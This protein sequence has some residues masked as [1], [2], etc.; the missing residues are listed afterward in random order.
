MK[1]LL[2]TC[3]FLL[4]SNIFSQIRENEYVL[5]FITTRE[6]LS[7]NYV[8]S[9]VSDQ[10]NFK[11][12]GTENGITKYNGFDFDYLKPSKHYDKLLNENIETFLFDKDNNLWIGTKSGGL[13]YL[14]LEKDLIKNVNHLIYNANNGDLRVFSIAQ[15]NN[16]YIWLGTWKNG[17]YVIDFKRN[18]LIKHLNFDLPIYAIKTDDFGNIWFGY[19]KKVI[20][21]HTTTKLTYVYKLPSPFS[22][23]IYDASRKRIWIT[24][25][26]N[27]TNLYFYDFNAE[28]INKI[29]SGIKSLFTKKISIDYKHRLW[30]GTWKNGLYRSNDELTVFDKVNLSKQAGVTNNSNYNTILEVHHDKNNL[31][32]IATAYGGLVKLSERKKFYNANEIITDNNILNQLNCTAIFK[33]QNQLFVGTTNGL[34][35]G[36]SFDDFKAFEFFKG[37]KIFNFYKHQNQLFIGHANG[38]SILDLK[39]KKII[40]NNNNFVKVTSFLADGNYLFIGT[41]EIG[42][43]ML[44]LNDLDNQN[45]YVLFSEKSTVKNKLR[46]NRISAIKKDD[47]GHIW[48]ATYKGIHQ[49]DTKTLSI[50]PQD[51]LL[52]QKSFPFIINTI[53]LKNNSIWAA[54]PNGLYELTYRDN[55][56]DIIRKLTLNE[57]LSS[58]FV[59]AVLFDKNDNLWLSTHTEIVK[60][61]YSKNTL[62]SYKQRDGIETTS[63]N[64]NSFFQTAEGEIYFGGNDNITFFNPDKISKSLLVPEVV[65]TNLRVNNQIVKFKDKTEILESNFSYSTKIK[66]NHDE[67]F[68]SIGFIADDFLD[69]QTVYY[70]YKLDGQQNK[71]IIL[72]NRNEINFAGLSPGNYT[73]TVMASRDN[74]NW[75]KPKQLTIQILKS[76]WLSNLALLGYCLVVFIIVW[77]F[78]KINK[79]RMILKRNYEI[80]KIDKQ[81]EIEISE[82]KLSFFTNISHEFRT[83]LTLIISP[84]K[85]LLELDSLPPKVQKN[86]MFI[87]RNTNRLLNL[88]NQLLDFR[89]ADHNLL[90][91]DISMGNFVRFAN[92][93]HLYF[94]DSINNKNI[95]YQFKHTTDEINLPFDRNKMEIVLC[96]LISNA[97]KYTNEGGNIVI[98]VEEDNEYCIFSIKDNGIGIKEEY[99]DK[100]F[101]RFFQIKSA[102]SARLIGSGIG[103]FFSKRIIDLH[104]GSIIVKS[105]PNK[106]TQFILKLSKDIK[107]YEDIIKHDY[108]KSDNIKGYQI[109]KKA[110]LPLNLNTKNTEQT[111]LIID[112]NADILDYLT[113][114]FSSEFNV[115]T[116]SNGQEGFDKATSEIPNIII[117]DVMMPVKDGITMC[118]ELKTQIA[119]SHI[120]IILLTARSSTVYEIEGL[121][122]GADDYLSKPFNANVIK[123]R[124]SSLIENQNRLKKH[125]LDK[126]SYEAVINPSEKTSEVENEFILRAVKL[127]EDNLDNSEFGIDQMIEHL[128]MSQSTLFR[129][130]KSLTGLSITGFIRSIR[131]KN[132]A[133]LIRTTDY[134]MS[135]ISYLVGFNDYKYFKTSFQKQFNCLPTQYK[136][137]TQKNN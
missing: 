98:K 25:L 14:N 68:F 45:A 76:P 18:K 83:P 12:I 95:N 30:I 77:Y 75:S 134:N 1:H 47:M 15:D 40:Y 97:I 32:W 73:L 71:K 82:A 107:L 11:W 43:A 34:Y 91:L 130:I 3:F 118:R 125:L 127:V 72:N 16:G 66:L 31:V 44:L 114:I 6:G 131:L 90:K 81:K 126:I 27:D 65:F 80:A 123:A 29:D 105:K 102:N 23:L 53:Y 117:S 38:F 58:D 137:K 21:Y 42:L 87:D 104:H 13:S 46:S 111:I 17:I 84:I 120:P 100:I 9:V 69:N 62:V 132:A 74:L 52:Y 136:E 115:I 61:N 129:K 110:L 2:V 113:D 116:A 35:E 39:T 133:I 37:I 56:L 26:D 7:H 36:S 96:N 60:Y 50:V 55:K 112:D 103:L 135:E 48:I 49:L 33:D 119:T 94:K 106:G 28:V 54:T 128:H 85:E 10:L 88:I 121:N 64:N 22:D 63:F 93:V 124:I 8:T 41:Q 101:D 57:G 59:C 5:E 92:E 67:N 109:D 108:L 99:L 89:K 51:E 70:K 79:N 24:V 86:L 20:R 122:L 4:S 78:L 19:G